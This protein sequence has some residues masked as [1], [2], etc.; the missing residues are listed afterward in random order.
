[1]LNVNMDFDPGIDLLTLNCQ[2]SHWCCII[3]SL[4]F[5]DFTLI[6]SDHSTSVYIKVVIHYEPVVLQITKVQHHM[7]LRYLVNCECYLYDQAGNWTF[8][9]VRS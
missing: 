8:F 5:D 9:N 3:Y 1:M 2:F 4:K 7:T 6:N